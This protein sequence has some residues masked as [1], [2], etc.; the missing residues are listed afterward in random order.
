[1]A[2]GGPRGVL[3]AR[4]ADERAAFALSA[5]SSAS[6]AYPVELAG[7]EDFSA[8]G[9]LFGHGYRLHEITGAG[10]GRLLCWICNSRLTTR[11]DNVDWLN[12]AIRYL[13]RADGVAL[14]S[15]Q[16]REESE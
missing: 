8:V 9:A 16:M 3:L 7:I 13:E 2:R 6:L 5:K 15:P 4:F 10:R 12:A 11:V 14:Y 1:M